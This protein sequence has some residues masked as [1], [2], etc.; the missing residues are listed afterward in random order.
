ME[1]KWNKRR[2]F[3]WMCGRGMLPRVDESAGGRG[4]K[5]K[6]ASGIVK[7]VSGDGAESVIERFDGSMRKGMRKGDRIAS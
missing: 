6:R 4:E 1:V 3:V 7:G 2:R 5:R